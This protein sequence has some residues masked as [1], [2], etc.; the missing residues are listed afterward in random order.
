MKIAKIPQ[1]WASLI[2][3]E[4]IKYILPLE[5]SVAPGE[6]LLIY[7]TDDD[8]RYREDFERANVYNLWY[9]ETVFGNL[10]EDLETAHFL[11]YVRA[12]N[13][14]LKKQDKIYVCDVHC[15]E[16]PVYSKSARP[17]ADI[18]TRPCKK[19]NYEAI[20]FRT[21]RKGS[22]EI[23]IPLG[24]EAWEN[25][26]LKEENI[27]L[28]WSE[29]FSKLT[30]WIVSFK[31]DQGFWD[32]QFE[33]VFTNDGKKVVWTM[34]NEDIHKTFAPIY[35]TDEKTGKKSFAGTTDI[36]HIGITDMEC[37]YPDRELVVKERERLL[38]PKVKEKPKEHREWVHIIYTPMGNKRR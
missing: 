2:M 31:D 33:V 28:Y 19:K 17:S 21:I 13:A 1:P 14:F 7:A 10:Y 22:H 24:K 32:E 37:L 29:E 30:D 18:L 9:N 11:G 27:N 20:T 12:S 15:F 25:L 5:E 36:L 8:E 16:K 23:V 38:N 4:T 6:L 34:L 26:I 35:E 3:T